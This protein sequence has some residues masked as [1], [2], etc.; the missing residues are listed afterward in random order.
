MLGAVEAIFINL[1]FKKRL[2]FCGGK[3]KTTVKP[4]TQVM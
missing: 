3:Q 4:Q 1:P 2:L